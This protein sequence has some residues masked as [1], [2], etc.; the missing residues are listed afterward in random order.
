MSAGHRPKWMSIR[1]RPAGRP[2]DV[3]GGDGEEGGRLGA[4]AAP[5]GGRGLLRPSLTVSTRRVVAGVHV[6]NAYDA[7]SQSSLIGV[8]E[9]PFYVDLSKVSNISVMLD[10]FRWLRHVGRSYALRLQIV[11]VFVA[12]FVLI[13]G[14]YVVVRRVRREEVLLSFLLPAVLECG[15]FGGALL[16]FLGLSAATNALAFQQARLVHHQLARYAVRPDAVPSTITSMYALGD[17]L[18]SEAL[19]PTGLK[20]SF[21]GFTVTMPVVRATA[22]AVGTVIIL[23]LQTTVTWLTFPGIVGS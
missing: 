3:G 5:R 4:R 16:I 23:L 12:A 11:F 7:D 6:A 22:A 17:L 2:D 10:L 9:Y 18:Q 14:V 15:V 21:A 19:D 8:A 13:C 1:P 20:E